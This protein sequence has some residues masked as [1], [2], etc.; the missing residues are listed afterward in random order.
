MTQ[1]TVAHQPPLSIG[2]SMQEY[3]SGLPY[4]PPG[5]LP[6]PGIKPVSLMSPVLAGRFFTTSTTW[7]APRKTC[8]DLH[9]S[10]LNMDTPKLKFWSGFL[11]QTGR[12]LGKCLEYYS[13]NSEILGQKIN[14]SFNLI[15][16]FFSLLV[17]MLVY[18][19]PTIFWEALRLLIKQKKIR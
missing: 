5:N 15:F 3:W 1:W 4:P 14:E 16:C 12:Q 18:F 10:L 17:D 11:P 8:S 13:G 6:D 9:W 2:V 19:F 7:E